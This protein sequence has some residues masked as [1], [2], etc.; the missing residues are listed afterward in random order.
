[1][2]TSTFQFDGQRSNWIQLLHEIEN[3]LATKG[4]SYLLIPAEVEARTRIPIIPDLNPEL[5]AMHEEANR[6]Y[7][8][9]LVMEQYTRDKALAEK[10]ILLLVDHHKLHLSIIENFLTKEILLQIFHIKNN[11]LLTTT[12]K[13]AQIIKFLYDHYGPNDT[14]DIAEI[15][16]ELRNATAEEGYHKLLSIHNNCILQINSIVQKDEDGNIILDPITHQPLYH[17][18]SDMT[19]K[20]IILPQL[21]TTDPIMQQIKLNAILNP[22]TTYN[23]IKTSILLSLKNA[24]SLN[25]IGIND[26]EKQI[27][28]VL[29]TKHSLHNNYK[30]NFTTNNNYNN[31]KKNSTKHYTGTCFICKGN[32]PTFECT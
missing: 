10:N 5:F 1:M 24:K 18:I 8:K 12:Q 21:D 13:I 14:N 22:H 17:S 32:H 25:L 7:M 31:N 29:A 3:S 26:S 30:K 28:K 23:A 6:P 19:L 27:S 20:N 15:T 9:K 16:A 11:V 4:I 2:L